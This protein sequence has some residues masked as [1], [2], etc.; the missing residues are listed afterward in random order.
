MSSI[1]QY[2][3]REPPRPTDANNH[4]APR[5]RTVTGN[6]FPRKYGF[7]HVRLWDHYFRATRVPQIRY[8]DRKSRGA[9]VTGNFHRKHGA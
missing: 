8:A 7:G 4:G 5:L 9:S 1:V 2:Q 6:R 3:Q